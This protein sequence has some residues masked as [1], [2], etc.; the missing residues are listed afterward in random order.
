MYSSETWRKFVIGVNSSKG[1][2]KISTNNTI[3]DWEYDY[4]SSLDN[5]RYNGSVSSI[6][7]LLK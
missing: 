4:E 1:V 2:V 5:N 6:E 7:A 3:T